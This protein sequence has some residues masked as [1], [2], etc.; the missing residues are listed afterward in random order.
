MGRE[1][2]KPAA[3]LVKQFNEQQNEL[4]PVENLLNECSA[5]L[6]KYVQLKNTFYH[7]SDV[8]WL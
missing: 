7:F 4:C 6:S 8:T 1:A 3:R 5:A 2:M